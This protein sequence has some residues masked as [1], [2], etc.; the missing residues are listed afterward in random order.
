MKKEIEEEKRKTIELKAAA[1]VLVC[2]Y[3]FHWFCKLQFTPNKTLVFVT[4]FEQQYKF[5]EVM[6]VSQ[7]LGYLFNDQNLL[8]QACT[9]A[10][11]DK[12]FNNAT[13]ET[14]GDMILFLHIGSHIY[15]NNTA[16]ICWIRHVL[17]PFIIKTLTMQLQRP[18]G[19]WSYL[20]TLKAAMQ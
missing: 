4:N 16:I 20:C 19:I 15:G 3:K 7:I 12:K 9:H 11:Y 8:D 13:L 5:I 18:V 14:L 17:T 10:S 1:S 6:D 2:L